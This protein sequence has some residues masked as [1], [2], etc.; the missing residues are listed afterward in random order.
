MIKFST[1]TAVRLS[2]LPVSVAATGCN[3][4]LLPERIRLSL[5]GKEQR[6]TAAAWREASL[7]FSS[8]R[9]GVDCRDVCAAPADLQHETEGVCDAS[10]AFGGPFSSPGDGR[11]CIID[12]TTLSAM[13]FHLW[14]AADRRPV[15]VH[16]NIFTA[17]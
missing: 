16:V 5:A 10:G 1:T 7:R 11:P 14:G 17:V 12:H 9:R 6:F 4:N 15:C 13:L 8:W 2:C 3:V